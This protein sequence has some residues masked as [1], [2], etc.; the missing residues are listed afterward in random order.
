MRSWKGEMPIA[1][2]SL[3]ALG[4]RAATMQSNRWFI[5]AVLFV[6]RFCI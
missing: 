6:T 4:A 3:Q 1:P 5:L 2:G